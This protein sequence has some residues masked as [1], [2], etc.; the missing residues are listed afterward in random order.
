MK[1]TTLLPKANPYERL[2]HEELQSAFSSFQEETGVLSLDGFCRLLDLIRLV[3][4]EEKPL[5]EDFQ[6][7]IFREL[8]ETR[9]V[10]ETTFVRR[11]NL[12]WCAR[13]E[14][15]EQRLFVIRPVVVRFDNPAI[16]PKP[17]LSELK[18]LRAK[19]LKL[20]KGRIGRLPLDQL[21]DELNKICK[22]YLAGLTV[23]DWTKL[24]QCYNDSRYCV[25]S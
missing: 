22:P 1:F 14:L 2:T 10:Y 19:F 13:A 16:K 12:Y 17:T 20:D 9:V 4:G 18:T 7:K 8:F 5:N 24:V 11:F 23:L 6:D 15:Y 3:D 21:D 25:L